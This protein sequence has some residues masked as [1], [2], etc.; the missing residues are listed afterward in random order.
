QESPGTVFVQVE[1]RGWRITAQALRDCIEAHS[2]LR[3]VL[4]RYAHALMVQI[5]QSTACN[6]VHSVEQRCARW[7]LETHDRVP[8]DVFELTQEFLGHMLGERRA[9]VN[10]VATTPQDRGLI[11][12]PRGRIE[13]RDGT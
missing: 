8:G 11:R 7:L 3:H 4:Q 13:V 2:G 5:S 9:T 12:Y 6:R 10:Q 1:G